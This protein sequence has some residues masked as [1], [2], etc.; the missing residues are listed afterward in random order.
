[1]MD[2][3]VYKLQS[4]GKEKYMMGSLKREKNC[5]CYGVAIIMHNNGRKNAKYIC[6]IS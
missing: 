1:M 4:K 6:A 2:L 5:Q 3:F